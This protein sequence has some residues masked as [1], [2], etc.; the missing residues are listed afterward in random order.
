MAEILSD[1][2][3]RRLTG[4]VETSAEAAQPQPLDDGLR[5]WYATRARQT[6]RLDLAVEDGGGLLVGEVVLNELDVD[7]GTANLRCLL[8]PEGRDRGLGT[9]A[10][11][12][13]C[14]HAFGTAGLRRLT[15]EVFA[16][17]P[18]AR[19]VY[20]RLGFVVT[21]ER[22]DGLVFD[23]VAVAALDMELTAEGFSARR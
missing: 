11:R 7:A 18:R 6:D 14:A 15:L 9:E 5:H 16:F 3:V 21:G 20:E 10:L 8:G 2:E 4:S 12:L 13:T 19:A 23:G 1:P 17:N 22:A